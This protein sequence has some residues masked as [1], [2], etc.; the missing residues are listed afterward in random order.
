MKIFTPLEL[1]VSER[2]LEHDRKFYWVATVK[3]HTSLSGGKVLFEQDCIADVMDSM[4]AQPLPDM[5]MPKPKSE[6]LVCGSYYSENGDPVTGGQVEVKFNNRKKTLN[7]FGDRKWLASMPSQPDAI[8]SMPIQYANAYGGEE[9]KLNP[10]GKGFRDAYLP[11][12]ERSEEVISSNT[13]SYQPAGFG[14]MDPS[15]MQRSRFQGTYDERYLEKFFP[16]YPEDMDWRLFMAAPQDQWFDQYFVGNEEYRIK[17]MHPSKPLLLGHLPGFLP[18]L[19][20]KE[21]V[22]ESQVNRELDLNLDTVWFFP[23]SDTIQLIWRTMV[24]VATDDA[25]NISHVLAGYESMDEPRRTFDHY[26]NALEKRIEN[27]DPLENNLNTKD[28][29]PLSMKSSIDRLKDSAVADV[30]VNALAQNMDA[31]SNKISQAVDSQLKAS[32]DEIK[33]QVQSASMA[34]E[35]KKEVL[36]QL[37]SNETNQN[38]DPDFALIMDK[39]EELLPGI[40]KGNV[41]E[42]ELG[43]FSFKKLE[44]ILDDIQA[45]SES[46]KADV[47]KNIAPEIVRLKEMLSTSGDGQALSE[48][49]RQQIIQQIESLES[50][51]EQPVI[52]KQPLPRLDIEEIKAQLLSTMP[53]V[54]Q[55]QNELHLM[56]SNPLLNQSPVLQQAR[57]KIIRVEKEAL[58]QLSSQLE[59]ARAQFHQTYLMGAHFS[60]DGLSPHQDDEEIRKQ[61]DNQVANNQV[62]S[63]Q[64][65]A[66]LTLSG[67]N[68]DGLD[69]SGCLMEQVVFKSCSLKG[70]NFQNAVLARASFV[71]SNF[72]QANFSGANLG[73]IEVEDCSFSQSNFIKTKLSH[74]QFVH[75]VFEG[76]QIVSPE[77]LEVNFE[78]CSF[79]YAQ[80][81][82]WILID[83]TL[84]NI[85]F[86]KASLSGFNFINCKLTDCEFGQT[87]MPS[88]VW[89]SANLNRVSFKLADMTSNC[90]VSGEDEDTVLNN[91]DFTR[92]KL[93]RAN[94]QYLVFSGCQFTKSELNSANLMG[95]DLRSNRFDGCEAIQAQFQKADLHGASFYQANLMESLM[96]KAKLYDVNFRESNLYGTDFIRS[97]VQGCDFAQ[98]NLDATILRDWRPS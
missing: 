46:K 74:S 36:N 1:S 63:N 67:L 92:T 85:S 19:I 25:E 77:L 88:T 44:E 81:E 21:Q 51:A 20:I 96:G 42:L 66:C 65:W 31:K 60:P 16:G 62:M 13:K 61:F 41:K 15:W 23:E 17:N 91:L 94:L 68:L 8:T 10:A 97:Y 28:L 33:D 82:D 35:K 89:S 58:A 4:G 30:E 70:T 86:N 78:S 43:L 53:Q 64:D 84:K 32:M 24:E 7:V 69:F 98:A 3:M 87:S 56:A 27:K 73:A 80:L 57:D 52:E 54:K 71:D 6:Y 50:L 79:D 83:R 34:D 5:G 47:A 45:F 9:Y 29:V 90:F 12:I 59:D 75:C 14:P 93:N 22:D 49:Q 76:A 55:A 26:S 48:E 18:R 38:M 72:D 37:A 40:S 95:S 11:N 39:L 2:T